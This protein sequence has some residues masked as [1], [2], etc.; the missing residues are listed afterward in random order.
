MAGATGSV[1]ALFASIGAKARS[2]ALPP[3]A[4]QDAPAAPAAPQDQQH[5]DG[6]GSSSSSSRMGGAT[7]AMAATAATL[8][9][10]AATADSSLLINRVH[11]PPPPPPSPPDAQQTAAEARPRNTTTASSAAGL[12]SAALLPPYAFSSHAAAPGA[13]PHLPAATVLAQGKPV[14]ARTDSG[15]G[16]ASLSAPSAPAPASA[17]S[18]ALHAAASAPASE[19]PWQSLPKDIFAGSLA[20][21]ATTVVGQPLDTIKT[22]FQAGIKAGGVWHTG[23]AMLRN[24]GLASFFRGM[25]SPLWLSAAYAGAY[26]ASYLQVRGRRAG[27]K[28]KGRQEVGLRGS[29]H[30]FRAA[31]FDQADTAVTGG[32]LRLCLAAPLARCR[33]LDQHS[34]CADFGGGDSLPHKRGRGGLGRE[35]ERTAP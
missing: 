5:Q 8:T 35:R 34:C 30:V 29:A 17:S 26:Y 21:M 28:E 3:T 14:L 13:K 1:K 15:S 2:P 10:A 33:R 25:S 11:V 32:V 4:L 23:R 12:G 18:A 7:A 31:F 6:G 27:R 9:A 24:E 16:G 20:G 19:A 22:R